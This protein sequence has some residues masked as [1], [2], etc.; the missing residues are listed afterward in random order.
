MNVQVTSDDIN[1]LIYKY[2][3][4]SGLSLSSYVSAVSCFK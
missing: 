4:E 3:Q 1:I 2:L